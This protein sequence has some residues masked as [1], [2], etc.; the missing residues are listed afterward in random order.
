[1]DSPT[2]YSSSAVVSPL[3]SLPH[4]AE[5]TR[6]QLSRHPLPLPRFW[7]RHPSPGTRA[8]L[9]QRVAV[10]L[11]DGS[12]VIVLPGSLVVMQDYRNAGSLRELFADYRWACAYS[13]KSFWRPT[14]PL[15]HQ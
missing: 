4:T 9:H 14:Q 6:P 1:M 5:L 10:E 15:P 3:Y 11:G 12:L 13:Y 2:P 7:R 8:D